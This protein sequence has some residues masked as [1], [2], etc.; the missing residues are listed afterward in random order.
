MLT[1]SP[2]EVK[3]LEEFKKMYPNI[4]EFFIFTDRVYD[5]S[6]IKKTH[7]GGYQ[8]LSHMNAREVDRFIYGMYSS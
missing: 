1:E 6:S 7:P 4:K 3:D 8:V 5:L 2:P